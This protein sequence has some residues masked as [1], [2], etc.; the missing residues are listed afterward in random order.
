VCMLMGHAAAL[1][2]YQQ[3]QCYQ[4]LRARNDP[5]LRARAR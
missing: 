3:V 2:C 4:L 1:Q 5:W